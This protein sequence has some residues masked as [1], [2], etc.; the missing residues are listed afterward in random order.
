MRD[1]ARDD[2]DAFREQHA[3]GRD[4]MIEIAE[5]VTQRD[6]HRKPGCLAAATAVRRNMNGLCSMNNRSVE[7]EKNKRLRWLW[8]P[9]HT[10]FESHT[11]AS[12]MPPLALASGTGK[13]VQ[14]YSTVGMLQ[15]SVTSALTPSDRRCWQ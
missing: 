15:V 2:M 8:M 1:K 7:G 5:Q 13:Q 3:S 14:L 4:A 9:P 6:K 12:S 11:H 10:T